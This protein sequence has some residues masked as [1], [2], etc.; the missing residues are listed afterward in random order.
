MGQV[1]KVLI[2]YSKGRIDTFHAK[3]KLEKLGLQEGEI[4]KLLA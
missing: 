4:E 1:E 3:T 2:A